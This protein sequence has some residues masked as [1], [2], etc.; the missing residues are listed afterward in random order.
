MSETVKG[1]IIRTYQVNAKPERAF[2]AFT[3]KDDLEMWKSDHYEIDPKK[4]GKFKM[5][6]ESD[7]FAVTGEF[8]EVVPDEKIVYSWRMMQYD[9][10]TGKLI[11]NFSQDSPTKVTVKFEKAGSSGTK[12]T[13]IHEGFP[14]RNEEFYMHETGWDLLIGRSL[15]AYLEMSRDEY[16]SWWKEQEPEWDQLWQK[17]SEEKMRAAE[18]AV[19]GT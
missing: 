1:T 19:V 2:K 8:L 10:K 16:L 15:K 5:G 9:E 17:L 4:G 7:G 6:L 3:N 11:P 18:Q 14:E 12:I 13:L